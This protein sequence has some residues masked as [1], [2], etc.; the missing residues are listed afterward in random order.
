MN[1]RHLVLFSILFSA[2]LEASEHF[3]GVDLWLPTAYKKQYSTLLDAAEKAKNDRYCFQLLS[4]GILEA[5]ST[6]NHMRFNF[7]CRAEDRKTFSI[8][9]DGNTLAVTNAYA[10]KQQKIEAAA[11]VEEERKQQQEEERKRQEEERKRQEEEKKQ[12]EEESKYRLIKKQEDE[13]SA[14]VLASKV[15]ARQ[16]EQSQYWTICRKIMRKRLRTFDKVTILTD[17]LPEPVI[18]ADQF[19]YTVSF[20]SISPSKKTL[21]F[22][23]I[24]IISALDYYSVDIKPRKRVSDKK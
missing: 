10:E 11:L 18:Q 17:S 16:R 23:V 13:E 21:H 1:Y 24:C 14:R 6:I 8:Q 12:Q 5:K 20:N 2:V 19:T 15:A 22:Q 3:E 4:G 9:V 7:R